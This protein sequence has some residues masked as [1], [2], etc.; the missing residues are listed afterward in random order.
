MMATTPSEQIH[1]VLVHGRRMRVC[2]RPGEGTPLL[3]CNGIGA[4][5]ELLQAFVDALDPSIPVVRFDVPGIGG[6]QLPRR[7]YNLAT[8]ARSLGRVLTELGFDRVDVLGISWGGALAQQFAAQH[9][10]R[11]R[12]LVLVSTSAGWMMVPGSPHVLRTMSTPRRYRDPEYGASV[13]GSIYGGAIRD[14]PGLGRR[15][16]AGQKTS[17]TSRRAYFLQLAAGAGW[18]SLPFLKLIRQ[19]TLVLAGD[20]DP[21][22]PLAN[23]RMLHRGL[24]HSTLHVFRDGH[25][26]LLVLADELAPVIA[27]FLR[28]DKADAG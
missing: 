23:A 18:T 13:A 6:S 2:V 11:C 14:D 20:D 25:L 27:D 3:L 28:P 26:G 1:Q 7:P 22:I 4:S 15:F 5:L 19:P 9:P 12:R 8:L 21:I 16:Y 17:V 10:R 24:P